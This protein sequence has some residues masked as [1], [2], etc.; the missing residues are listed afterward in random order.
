MTRWVMPGLIIVLF[1]QLLFLYAVY[2]GVQQQEKAHK[3]IAQELSTLIAEAAKLEV[4]DDLQKLAGKVAARNN[5]LIDRRNNPLARLAKLQKDCPNN[6]SVVSY[7]ADLT[8]GKIVL[9]AGDFTPP[10]IP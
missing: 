6:V 1:A 8:G 7:S 5:W 2:V 10:L 9:T 3:N 4:N